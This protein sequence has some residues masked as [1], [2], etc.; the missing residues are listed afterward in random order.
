MLHTVINLVD[1]PDEFVFLTIK[2]NESHRI[3]AQQVDE[4][5]N[6]SL[7]VLCATRD[8]EISKKVTQV[9]KDQEYEMTSLW[10]AR[11]ATMSS[12]SACLI[13]E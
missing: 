10:H 6:L 4:R 7:H 5:G 11:L 12:L 2:M 3:E 8:S 1:C 13:A 9:M